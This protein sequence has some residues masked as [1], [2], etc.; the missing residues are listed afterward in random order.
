M[1]KVKITV[2]KTTFDGELTAR[3]GVEGLDACPMHRERQ[4][5]TPITP[6]RKV[7]VMKPGK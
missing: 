3:Y 4:I 6:S 7:S 2:Q 1:N 5:F